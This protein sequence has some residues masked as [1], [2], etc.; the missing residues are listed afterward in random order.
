MNS[1]EGGIMFSKGDYLV[2]KLEGVCQVMDI[3]PIDET[4]KIYYIM[5]RVTDPGCKVYS[6]V[7]NQ[8]VVRRPLVTVEEVNELL[9]NAGTLPL[10]EVGN[11][12]NREACYKAALKSGEFT[13][14]GRILKTIYTRKKSR[15]A[16]GKKSTSLDERYMEATKKL[17]LGELSMTLQVNE[18]E[19]VQYLKDH[20]GLQ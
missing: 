15:S 5:E 6:P 10:I 12:R 17:L 7:D 11:E 9:Q 2:Y 8:A 1:E 16:R 14:W 3:G 20:I 19:A 4:G 18:A 13:E